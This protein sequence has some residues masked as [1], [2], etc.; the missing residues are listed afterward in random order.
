MQQ[1]LNQ[2]FLLKGSVCRGGTLSF[3][4]PVPSQCFCVLF[5]Y[6]FCVVIHLTPK[7]CIKVSSEEAIHEVPLDLEVGSYSL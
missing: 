5:P 6:L 3:G 2:R 1:S 4:L 7:P